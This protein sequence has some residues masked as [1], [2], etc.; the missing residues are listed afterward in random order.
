MGANQAKGTY[1]ST[2]EEGSRYARRGTPV[3]VKVNVQNPFVSEDDVFYDIQREIIQSRFGKEKIEDLTETEADLLA[4][5]VTEHFTTE[6][7]DSIYMPQS[8]TQEGEL[9]VFDRSKVTIMDDARIEYENAVHAS[10]QTTLQLEFIPDAEFLKTD[11][12]IELR[13]KQKKVRKDLAR[14]N[15][16]IK[17]R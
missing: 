10:T 3:K 4:E 14:L 5:M 9:I 6:G 7:F 12:P 15:Q 16:L 2:E 8:E 11:K 1:V 13:E 17:C